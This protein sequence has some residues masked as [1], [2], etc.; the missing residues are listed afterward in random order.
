MDK[1]VSTEET[2]GD[3]DDRAADGVSVLLALQHRSTKQLKG[4]YGPS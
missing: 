4:S 1:E 3:L 2:S